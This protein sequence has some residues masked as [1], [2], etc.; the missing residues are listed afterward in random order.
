M[1]KGVDNFMA[2]KMLSMKRLSSDRFLF[3][4][5]KSSNAIICRQIILTNFHQFLVKLVNKKIF[6]L[7]FENKV[8]FSVYLNGISVCQKNIHLHVTNSQNRF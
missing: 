1:N 7:F 6:H 4:L 3:Y 2:S 8:L 5:Q